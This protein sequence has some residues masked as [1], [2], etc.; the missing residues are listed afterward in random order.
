MFCS[1]RRGNDGH[2]RSFPPASTPRI[3]R[4]HGEPE[5]NRWRR[6]RNVINTDIWIILLSSHNPSHLHPY[7]HTSTNRKLVPANQLA[8][9]GSDRSRVDWVNDLRG[10]EGRGGAGRGGR[11]LGDSGV[12]KWRKRISALGTA[13][14]NWFHWQNFKEE[15]E[16]DNPP[17]H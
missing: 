2:R 9:H 13:W 10:G 12:Q 11:C 16:G 8:A 3:C 17:K 6:R 15:E 14:C 4:V 5:G 1:Y 7:K